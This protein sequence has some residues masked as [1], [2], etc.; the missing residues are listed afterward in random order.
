MWEEPRNMKCMRPPSVAMFF[1]TYFLQG[2][3]GGGEVWPPGS[4]TE[5]T[6]F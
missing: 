2:G 4:A 6:E 1:V 3:P 5:S